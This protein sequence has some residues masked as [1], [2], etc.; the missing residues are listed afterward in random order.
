MAKSGF[1]ALASLD[2]ENLFKMQNLRRA[3]HVPNRIG[4]QIVD[5]IIKSREIYRCVIETAVAFANDARFIGQLGNITKENNHRALADFSNAGFEQALDH[6]GESIVVKT[7][8]TLDVVM[9][10]EQFVNVVEILHL[11]RDAFVPDI[12][13]FLIARLQLYQ[14]LTTGFADSQFF[15]RSFICLLVN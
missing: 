14:F 4:L 3:D 12:D 1:I 13:V 6:A 11:E 7:F 15:C 9:D 10:I 5:A 2:L 8:T